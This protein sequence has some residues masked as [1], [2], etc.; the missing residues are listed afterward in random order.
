[1]TRSTCNRRAGLHPTFTLSP[2][3]ALTS[4]S[5][6]FGLKRLKDVHAF[7]EHID[8]DA[9]GSCDLAE[10]RVFLDEVVFVLDDLLTGASHAPGSDACDT[11][12]PRRQIRIV[13]F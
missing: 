11:T 8:T 2:T 10:F 3:L 13:P 9:D 1:M 7:M 12:P 5:A 4:R 6:E